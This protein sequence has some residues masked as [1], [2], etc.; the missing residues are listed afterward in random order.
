MKVFSFELVQQRWQI[1]APFTWLVS[2]LV[3][4]PAIIRKPYCIFRSGT[5]CFTV[6]RL[7]D[8]GEGRGLATG[9]VVNI[10]TPVLSL[11]IRSQLGWYT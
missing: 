10:Q 3:A 4:L 11:N 5:L 1:F 2:L 7:T 8:L 9:N 6:L